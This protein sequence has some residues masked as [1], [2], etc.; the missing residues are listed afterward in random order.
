MRIAKILAVAIV[1]IFYPKSMTNSINPSTYCCVHFFQMAQFKGS[2]I[3]NALASAA[4][5]AVIVGTSLYV[6]NLSAG[7]NSTSSSTAT[8][9]FNSAS[10]TWTSTFTD[11]TTSIHQSSPS[12]TTT[13]LVSTSS[14]QTT[15]TTSSHQTSTSNT[16]Y[17]F[18]TTAK[19]IGTIS[20]IDPQNYPAEYL[21]YSL[22]N[23]GDLWAFG[24]GDDTSTTIYTQSQTVSGR[25]EPIQTV[26]DPNTG[27]GFIIGTLEGAPFCCKF[28]YIAIYNPQGNAISNVTLPSSWVPNS[29]F[30][31]T[32]DPQNSY[33]YVGF[34]TANSNNI[35][36]F[37]SK[38]NSVVGKIDTASDSWFGLTYFN[39]L[40][41]NVITPLYGQGSGSEPF[42]VQVISTLNNTVLNTVS[43]PSQR[44]TPTPVINP[45]TGEVYLPGS[46]NIT[47][48]DSTLHRIGTIALNGSSGWLA[49][50]PN[51]EQIFADTG[52]NAVS[53]IDSPSNTV[54][55]VLQVG[56]SP[57]SIVYN[58]QNSLVY[59]INVDDQ[60]I[61]II[62]P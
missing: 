4:V 43:I 3:K 62:Q 1:H 30:G 39:G 19:V 12:T 47:V 2:M 42:L 46:S 38:T 53:V 56:N 34:S 59:V 48:T 10:Q 24:I 15:S 35:T 54:M 51:T 52:S 18:L 32:Y 25:N 16:S 40:I 44:F 61:S 28:A 14:I 5:I 21:S 58:R 37:N 13:S 29:V 26:V 60:S 23:H 8:G 57:Q 9:N 27:Y 17:A 6:A 41:Y 31:V 11:S 49:Y 36:I 33:L 45:I 7:S 20:N 50:D 22:V 55:Q